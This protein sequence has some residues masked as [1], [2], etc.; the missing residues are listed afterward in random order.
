MLN[1]DSSEPS[2]ALPIGSGVAS[3][4]DPLLEAL[5]VVTRLLSRSVSAETLRAGLPL[6]DHRLTVDLFPRAAH[7]AGLTAKLV[8]R[9][10]DQLPNLLLPAI[11]LLN[12][13]RTCV[14]TSRSKDG[15][16]F[17]VI[18]PET[19]SGHDELTRE[20]LEKAYRGYAFLIK[21]T[22]VPEDKEA[23]DKVSDRHWFWGVMRRS[24]RVYRDVFA[25]SFLVNMFALAMPIYILNVY[26]RV[27][28]NQAEE[29][30]WVMTIAVGGVFLFEAVM[31]AM[32]SYFLDLAARRS[33][34]VLSAT[35]CEKMLGLR[36][37]A[38]PPSIGGLANQVS[39]FDRLR[40][41]LTATTMT[42]VIDLPFMV[43]FLL[44]IYWIAGPLV[45]IPLAAVPLVLIYALL[46][47]PALRGATADVM[48]TS[49]RRHATL[50]ESLSGL[51]AVRILGGESIQQRRWEHLTE[52][53]SKA[54]MR[55]RQISGSSVMF[56]NLLRNVTWLAMAV[57]GVYMLIQGDMTQGGL[58]AVLLLT[59][60]AVSPMAQVAGLATRYNQAMLALKRLNELMALPQDR[61]EGRSYVHRERLEGMFEFSDVAF[62]YPH[63]DQPAIEGIDF[64]VMPGERVGI[65]GPIGSGKTTLGKLMLGHYEATHGTVR[66]DGF[67]IRQFDPAALRRNVG[68]ATQDVFLFHGTL[69]ENIAMGAPWA[70]DES[71]LQAAELAHVTDFASR[72][73]HGFD[74]QVGERGEMLSGGQRQAV[75]L[76]RA[77]LLDPPVL[78]LDEPTSSMDNATET[79]LK[80]TL[81]QYIKGRTL[82]IVTHR[83][84]LLDLVTRLIVLEQGR[85]IADGPRAEILEA[86][87]QGRIGK[88][89][90]KAR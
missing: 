43:L 52:S 37:D 9:R 13:G 83:A 35:I 70:D 22:Y 16:K 31:R 17:N 86:L 20:E 57:G 34:Q 50:I 6:V 2:V 47:Q 75:S 41:F 19:E 51:E 69:R 27:V 68:C 18:W 38:R 40:D 73:P 32:R 78:L 39:E 55:A 79:A 15:D 46:I 14:L 89:A 30:L 72:H 76:A 12:D 67:D 77:L 1:S 84:S 53:M 44:L 3:R 7:R 33:E 88:T 45:F 42:T 82:M 11:L 28:P 58:I 56:A 21:T 64:K 90:M 36:M 54:G 29:T 66:V 62:T 25:A 59:M 65:I 26:D 80:N 24:W 63:Q 5:L 71:I 49:S 81:R 87:R 10:L 85:V 74:M 4:H 8:R 61:P 60:R 48:K 23:G